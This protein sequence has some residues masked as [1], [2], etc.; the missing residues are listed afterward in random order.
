MIDYQR[1]NFFPQKESIDIKSLNLLLNKN[2]LDFKLENNFEIK[3]V[4]SLE[5]IYSDSV[6]L[7]IN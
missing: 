2:L 5:N 7:Q 1:T 4:S 6:I 3:N